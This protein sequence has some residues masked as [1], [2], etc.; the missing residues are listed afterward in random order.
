MSIS[1]VDGWL[2]EKIPNEAK[3]TGE[4]P[5]VLSRRRSCNPRV[6]AAL[7]A[8]PPR[9]F[10]PSHYPPNPGR[11]QHGAAHSQPFT[12]IKGTNDMAAMPA[13]L[14]LSLGANLVGRSWA[15]AIAFLATPVY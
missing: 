3:C 11:R 15:G 9:D 13:S 12:L 8:L 7:G 14:K 5:R 1:R 2:Q 4:C 10:H 6:A